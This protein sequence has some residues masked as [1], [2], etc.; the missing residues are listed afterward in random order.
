MGDSI[1]DFWINNDS[2]F[3]AA[4]PN[5]D[6]GISGQTTAQMLL[7]FRQDMINLKTG[8][9]KIFMVKAPF[10]KEIAGLL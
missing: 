3:F 10:K 9:V 5:L 6:R 2:V 4:K 8:V 1:T 7:R